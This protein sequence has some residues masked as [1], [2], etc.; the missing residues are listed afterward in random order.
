MV[1]E[2]QEVM[3]CSNQISVITR[4]SFWGL[5]QCLCSRNSLGMVW[6]GTL[7]ILLRHDV[8]KVQVVWVELTLAVSCADKGV[9]GIVCRAS[10]GMTVTVC[11]KTTSDTGD[12]GLIFN[13][14]ETCKCKIYFHRQLTQK[15]IGWIRLRIPV[16]DFLPPFRG[17]LFVTAEISN[18]S[19]GISATFSKKT[20]SR[21][22][23]IL[24]ISSPGWNH[25]H[26][27]MSETKCRKSNFQLSKTRPRSSPDCTRNSLWT[28]C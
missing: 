2:S 16:V 11:W 18:S 10:G 4:C 3:G 12:C 25:T 23:A 6:Y 13:T 1:C 7:M 22:W 15:R 9:E 17:A 14:A 8:L 5:Q 26:T 24:T 19:W 28:W 21:I 20:F 27:K